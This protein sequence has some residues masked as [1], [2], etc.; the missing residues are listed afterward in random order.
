M[1]CRADDSNVRLRGDDAV[2]NGVS[3]EFTDGV[4]F[5]TPHDVG[6]MGLGG[7]HA[8]VQRDGHFL[9]ALAF[10]EKLDDLA[11][12]WR[13]TARRRRGIGRTRLLSEKA[14]KHH[15]PDLRGE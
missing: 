4:A 1:P 12:A 9:A 5:E 14:V 8:E 6:A 7:F 3:H 10:G 13:K 11:L 2:T 15:L